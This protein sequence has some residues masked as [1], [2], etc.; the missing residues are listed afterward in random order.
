M[1]MTMNYD[2]NGDDNDDD[3]DDE[4]SRARLRRGRRVT[5]DRRLGPARCTS[6]LIYR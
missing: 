4:A 3:D 1:A 2:V 5:T 6:L